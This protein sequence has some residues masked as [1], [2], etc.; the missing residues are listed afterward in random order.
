MGENWDRL[1]VFTRKSGWM[2]DRSSRKKVWDFGCSNHR[3]VKN[4]GAY[5][6]W[7]TG[8]DVV[9]S[10]GGQ[11]Q[12]IGG[13]VIDF[14]KNGNSLNYFAEIVDKEYRLYV[15]NVTVNGI[16]YTNCSLVYDFGTDSWRVREMYDQMTIFAKYFDTTLGDERLY[17]GDTTGQVW[18]HSKYTDT[19]PVYG[20]SQTVSSPDNSKPIA[21]TFEITIA[22][23]GA[24]VEKDLNNLWAYADKAGGLQLKGRILDKNSRVIAPY[25]TIGDLRQFVNS[26]HV[27]IEHGAILQIEGV[28]YSNNPYWSFY[29]LELDIVKYS[30][31]LKT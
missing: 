1:V 20:D 23:G 8:Q 3:T 5:M 17:M 12:P 16:S 26:F 21:S 19:T 31:V 28:E 7:C 6:I 11:P 25:M 24:S 15:G 13:E 4:Y 22:L 18:D 29:G 30:N 10:T 9:L 2:Y 27:D 14:I